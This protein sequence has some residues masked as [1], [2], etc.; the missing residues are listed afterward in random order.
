MSP[1]QD[2]NDIS[3]LD[4]HIRFVDVLEDVGLSEQNLVLWP[5]SPGLECW[6]F[7]FSNRVKMIN[8][9]KTC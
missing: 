8:Q 2:L 4:F 5:H 6:N 9:V 1:V 7:Y 3:V